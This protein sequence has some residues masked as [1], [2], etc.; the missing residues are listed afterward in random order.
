[1]KRILVAVATLAFLFGYVDTAK[2]VT[3]YTTTHQGGATDFL[4]PDPV[5]VD[6][7]GNTGTTPIAVGTI[8]VILGVILLGWRGELRRSWPIWALGLPIAA[9]ALRVLAQ[10][11]AK[12]GMETLPS[13][14]FAGL[15]GYTVSLAI[16][17]GVNAG[18]GQRLADVYAPGF[19]WLALTGVTN[20]LAILALN[21][22]L[23]CGRLTTVSPLVACAPLFSLALGYLVFREKQLTARTVVAVLIIVPSVVSIALAR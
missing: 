2:A 10:A 16:A 6:T 11:L 9:A 5:E 4:H 15:V 20:G 17:I 23:L 18:R 21:S 13:A 19:W 22:A 12:I 1:M 7:L 8:G 14:L 3:I